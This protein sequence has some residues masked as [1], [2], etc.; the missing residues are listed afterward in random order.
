MEHIQSPE[1]KKARRTY[2]RLMRGTTRDVTVAF[3]SVKTRSQVGKNQVAYLQGRTP[4]YAR[5]T[6]YDNDRNNPTTDDHL[7]GMMNANDQ[8]RFDEWHAAR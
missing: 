1:T 7:K 5:Y 8:A 6:S 3:W 2:N 4:G